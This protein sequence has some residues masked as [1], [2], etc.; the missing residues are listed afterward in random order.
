MSSSLLSAQASSSGALSLTLR[1]VRGSG[2][3]PERRDLL[4]GRLPD[5][6]HSLRRRRAC[7]V[8]PAD[9]DDYVSLQWLRWHGGTLAL[10]TNGQA[11]RDMVAAAQRS[12]C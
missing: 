1:D 7:E 2:V 4:A 5:A 6:A 3:S 9:I 8:P 11:V 10:T 12:P